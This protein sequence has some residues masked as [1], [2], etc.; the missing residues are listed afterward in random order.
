[1][2]A[3]NLRE[4]DHLAPVIQFEAYRARRF[5]SRTKY[6]WDG[7][8]PVFSETKLLFFLDV[9][10]VMSYCSSFNY[11]FEDLQLV[12][13]ERVQQRGNRPYCQG[14]QATRKAIAVPADFLAYN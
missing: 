6:L 9:D 12:L 7:K 2:P 10:D 4:P 13:C 11:Q 14:F 1:M 8:V 3:L 5:L